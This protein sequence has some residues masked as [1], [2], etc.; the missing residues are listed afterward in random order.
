MNSPEQNNKDEDTLFARVCLILEKSRKETVRAVNSNMVICYWLIGR[1][2]VVEIQ[3][4]EQ[5]A[6]YGGQVINNLSTGLQKRYGSGFSIANLKRF[7]QFYLAYP[8][9]LTGFLSESVLSIES[10]PRQGA[11]LQTETYRSCFEGIM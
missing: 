10:A 2:I 1:E 7:R 6:E 9:R 11:N 3:S 8:D 4:G 5:R